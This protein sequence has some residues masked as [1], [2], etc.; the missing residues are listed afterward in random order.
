MEINTIDYLKELTVRF[1]VRKNENDDYINS[2]ANTYYLDDVIFNKDP[3]PRTKIE[4]G[5]KQVSVADLAKIT[6]AN[7]IIQINA[8]KNAQI[9]VYNVVGKLVA[10]NK[11]LVP[12]AKGVYIVNVIA[13]GEKQVTKVLVK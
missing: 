8:T 13:G 1:D 7:G 10:S 11:T 9:Q 12:V 2:P 4:T 3:E 6:T 5:I